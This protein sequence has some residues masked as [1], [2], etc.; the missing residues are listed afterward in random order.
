MPPF[1]AASLNCALPLL[2]TLHSFLIHNLVSRTTQVAS[3]RP[4]VRTHRGSLH[5]EQGMW[6][7]L[8]K[9]RQDPRTPRVVE[10]R[11]PSVS[12]SS[13]IL[14]LLQLRGAGACR[15][16]RCASERR[17]GCKTPVDDR[18]EEMVVQNLPEV[19]A[20]A[21]V[22]LGICARGGAYERC[23]FQASPTRLAQDFRRGCIL[24]RLQIGM[25]RLRRGRCGRFHARRRRPE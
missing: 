8:G 14:R 11:A 9:L 16:R 17:S 3:S 20:S 7:A 24:R 19:P 13:S 6:D 4:S 1:S 18:T 5:A 23:V 25:V 21:T 22:R 15:A 10:P 12:P 2:C